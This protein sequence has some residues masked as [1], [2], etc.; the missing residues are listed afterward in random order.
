MDSGQTKNS[1]APNSNPAL[2]MSRGTNPEQKE[3]QSKTTTNSEPL[4]TQSRTTNGHKP[5]QIVAECVLENASNN[6]AERLDR[7]SE[8]TNEALAEELQRDDQRKE[9]GSR[10]TTAAPAPE[11]AASTSNELTETPIELDPNPKSSRL[12]NQLQKY[13]MKSRWT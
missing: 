9:R 2:A 4:A 5:T 7:R 13:L 1:S 10:V 12:I 3:S 6:C 11:P 8:V